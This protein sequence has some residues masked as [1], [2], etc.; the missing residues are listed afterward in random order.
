[1]G[2]KRVAGSGVDVIISKAVPP[3][4]ST[5]LP[6]GRITPAHS[7]LCPRWRAGSRKNGGARESRDMP[8]VSKFVQT[9]R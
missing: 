3:L 2:L 8:R 5:W 6:I 4:P 1:V 9:R 7:Y